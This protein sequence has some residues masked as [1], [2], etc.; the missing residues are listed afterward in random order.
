VVSVAR[1]S[2][3]SHISASAGAQLS[4]DSTN[5]SVPQAVTLKS[6]IDPGTHDEVA[7]FELTSP[8]LIPQSV[9]V[10]ATE[11][12]RAAVVTAPDS[13]H[14]DEGAQGA[15]QVSLASQPDH[16]VQ[17]DVVLTGSDHLAISSG[18][19]LS[20]TPQDFAVPQS[21]AIDA[22]QDGDA[23]SDSATITISVDGL[24]TRAVSVVANDDEGVA[25]AITSSSTTK[26]VEDELNEFP[27]ATTGSPAVSLLLLDDAGSL[28]I[29]DD[30]TLSGRLVGGLQRVTLVASNGVG[31]IA[32]Q[33][34]EISPKVDCL[35]TAPAPDAVVSGVDVEFV[36]ML[37]D[38]GIY[39]SITVALYIDGTEVDS[40]DE[41]GGGRRIAWDTTAYAEGPHHLKIHAEK[42]YPTPYWTCER[43]IDV[44]VDNVPDPEPEPEMDAGM[45]AGQEPASEPDAAAGMDAGSGPDSEDHDT[46]IADGGR[47]TAADA[48]PSAP[49]A[50]DAAAHSR[51][52]LRD[53]SRA[54]AGADADTDAGTAVDTG[55]GCTCRVATARLPRGE[56][57]LFVLLA[58][59]RM[60]R[61]RR[62]R[63][64]ATAVI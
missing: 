43:E 31:P 27:V 62:S 12:P 10:H 61:R 36:A 15:L 28:R 24:A 22:M 25:P 45:D 54:D 51:N 44:T 11:D 21:V 1:A 49:G 32:A 47:S 60:R 46:S 7:V 64:H 8:G 53:A 57:A 17:V 20:F 59:L 14:V 13:L 56:T 55:S 23:D 63:T 42:G 4:F 5:W 18:T 37:V 40:G 3:S 9:T 58:L 26:F 33:T 38:E 52:T 16:A 29:S 6:T 19:S 30:N 48:S 39:S 41:L 35:L 34:F 2:G 50:N